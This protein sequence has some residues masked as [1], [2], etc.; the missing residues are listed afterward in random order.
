MSNDECESARGHMNSGAAWTVETKLASNGD[1]YSVIAVPCRP[2]LAAGASPPPRLTVDEA[3][4]RFRSYAGVSGVEDIPDRLVKFF[5]DT[6]ATPTAKVRQIIWAD[7][8][9]AVIAEL[10]ERH[11][12]PWAE[13]YDRARQ[14][15][16][17]FAANCSV[18]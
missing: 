4:S 10:G 16:L 9:S 1:V 6:G 12:L 18:S 13:F 2:A 8:A 11:P 7:G 3:A 17:W 14:H 5:A 15:M